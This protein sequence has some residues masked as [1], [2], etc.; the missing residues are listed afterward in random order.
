MPFP[1]G[2][3]I[4]YAKVTALP[5]PVSYSGAGICVSFKLHWPKLGSQVWQPTFSPA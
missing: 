3:L 5:Q 4:Q 1:L 2:I